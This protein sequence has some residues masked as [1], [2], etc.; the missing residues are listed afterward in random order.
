MYSS[1]H[2]PCLCCFILWI[3]NVMVGHRTRFVA[4]GLNKSSRVATESSV[5]FTICI[6][7]DASAC[8]AVALCPDFVFGSL[9]F[10]YFPF[11][12]SFPF[13]FPPLPKLPSCAR[14]GQILYCFL[15]LHLYLQPANLH[16]HSKLLTRLLIGS[17]SPTTLTINPKL[18]LS[19]SRMYKEDLT[20]KENYCK[21]SNDLYFSH[22]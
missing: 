11:P 14:S 19:Y 12:L 18:M 22:P 20:V 8:V 7:E 6:G 4:R 10:K 2:W 16:K 5:L 1:V 15:V 3:S 17:F 9:R 21:F 13:S